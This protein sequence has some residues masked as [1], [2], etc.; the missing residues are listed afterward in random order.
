MGNSSATAALCPPLQ[1]GSNGGVVLARLLNRRDR[2][3]SPN[4]ACF[5]RMAPRA[6]LMHGHLHQEDD[7]DDVINAMGPP[8]LSGAV[9]MF[10]SVASV[11]DRR[12]GSS[13]CDAAASTTRV[14]SDVPSAA[15]SQHAAHHSPPSRPTTLNRATLIDTRPPSDVTSAEQPIKHGA[16]ASD[17]TSAAGG[18][19]L[20]PCQNATVSRAPSFHGACPAR[21]V[22]LTR[23]HA[24]VVVTSAQ[25][26][27]CESTAS[28]CDKAANATVNG[29]TPTAPALRR[30][31][32]NP[33]DSKTASDV[34]D[35]CSVRERRNGGES[36]QSG[37]V[38]ESVSRR[39]RTES[40]DAGD[41]LVPSLRV[42]TSAQTEAASRDVDARVV[43]MQEETSVSDVVRSRTRTPRKKRVRR[44]RKDSTQARTARAEQKSRDD[45]EHNAAYSVVSFGDDARVI[46]EKMPPRKS[47]A[48]AATDLD[49]AAPLMKHKHEEMCS[50]CSVRPASSQRSD[51]AFSANQLSFDDPDPATA[52]CALPLGILGTPSSSCESLRSSPRRGSNSS[53]S[54]TT[55]TGQST[56]VTSG[57]SSP[58][59]S[60]SPQ[61]ETSS[62]SEVARKLVLNVFASPSRRASA[63]GKQSLWTKLR[64]DSRSSECGESASS[65]VAPATRTSDEQER[66]VP[67]GVCASR[68][69]DE[70]IAQ[71]A[72]DAHIT[73]KRVSFVG[74]GEEGVRPKR[75]SGRQRW[76]EATQRVRQESTVNPTYVSHEMSLRC[77]R[78]KTR[79]AAAFRLP[80]FHGSNSNFPCN[81]VV[82]L[83]MFAV[84]SDRRD[85]EVIRFG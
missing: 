42:L 68:G 73:K 52:G 53:A 46:F 79:E 33:F 69:L 27:T 5:N 15:Q 14:C 41:E 71:E 38:S 21:S 66:V 10:N 50:R 18:R 51:A 31:R 9:S 28:E 39:T 63:A 76:G 13:D 32:V 19:G 82:L 59:P 80:M 36:E 3:P 75:A 40:K 78:I 1:S 2:S 48:G 83:N 45:V 84:R 23:S 62:L 64:L 58:S 20:T 61:H 60:S 30:Q 44:D 55:M 65:E 16:L 7:D 85:V 8:Q 35:S 29:S 34:I 67:N 74:A 11:S 47:E 57:P 25:R 22:T 37:D 4:S 77:N 12:G 24:D 81:F 17:A 26:S 72:A 43:P 6:S 54:S 56:S 49:P 70:D